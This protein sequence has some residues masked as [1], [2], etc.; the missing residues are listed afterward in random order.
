MNVKNCITCG[1][2]YN[3]DGFK[4]CQNCRRNNENDFV[5]LKEYLYKNPGADISEVHEATEVDTK[6]IIEFLKEGRLEI[7]GGGNLVLE[8]ESCGV[9]ITTGRF[10]DKCTAELQRELGQ[11]MVSPKVEKP[12]IEQKEK[13]KFR[14]IDRYENKK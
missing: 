8:C 14:V 9:S 6:K 5:K 1:K 3:Y 2:I 12:K 10:C 7:T 4:I 11:A 13:S